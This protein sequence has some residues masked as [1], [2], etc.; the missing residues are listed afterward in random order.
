MCF[1]LFL[2]GFFSTKYFEILIWHTVFLVRK[3]LSFFNDHEKNTHKYSSLIMTKYNQKLLY[4]LLNKNSG[5]LAK[6]LLYLP[7]KSK[8]KGLSLF[9]RPPRFRKASGKEHR[10]WNSKLM[11][12]LRCYFIFLSEY[13]NIKFPSIDQA[14]ASI[15]ELQASLSRKFIDFPSIEWA[16]TSKFSSEHEHEPSPE[17]RNNLFFA[18]KW[19]FQTYRK[20]WRLENE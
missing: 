12:E 4:F 3:G 8:L 11:R 17:T 15:F 20:F 7:S 18:Q 19:M 10:W 6:G 1:V 13:T 2:C 9:V 14:R 5:K 16:R